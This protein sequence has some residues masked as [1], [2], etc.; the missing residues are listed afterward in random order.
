MRIFLAECDFFSIDSNVTDGYNENHEAG[1]DDIVVLVR[2]KAL[3]K[4][5]AEAFLN[6]GIPYELVDNKP[7]YK[8]KPIC[9]II[10][11]FKFLVNSNHLFDL[12]VDVNKSLFSL[13]NPVRILLSEIIDLYFSDKKNKYGQEIKRLLDFAENFQSTD[14]FLAKMALGFSEDV[15]KRKTHNVKVMTMHAAKGLE[16]EHV[17]IAGCEDK[18]I[19]YGLYATQKSDYEEEKRLFYVAITR[20][21]KHLYLTSAK[22]RILNGQKLNLTTSP[23]VEKIKK[24]LLKEEKNNY[25]KKLKKEDSQLKL[26]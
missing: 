4:S 1:L 19:P 14:E 12:N 6:H 25:Q 24:D 9:D 15:Y 8:E 3:M 10:N 5:I 16:F 11:V 7:F 18:L 20:S 2:T 23:F 26:F 13:D 21:K 17:F 22:S